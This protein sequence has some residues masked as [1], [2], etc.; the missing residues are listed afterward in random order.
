MKSIEPAFCTADYEKVS[1]TDLGEL[2]FPSDSLGISRVTAARSALGDFGTMNFE[3]KKQPITVRAMSA[4]HSL[5]PNRYRAKVEPYLL[6][7]YGVELIEV[8]SVITP[9]VT[10]CI[11]CRDLWR[12]E[13]DPNW[14]NRTIQLALRRDQ[15]D[16]AAALLMATSLAAKNICGFVDEGSTGAAFE[17]KLK[18]R[19]F[20]EIGYQRHPTCECTRLETKNL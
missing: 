12:S 5:S 3:A 11:G 14:C 4:N 20:R 1:K 13:N 10:A 15:L 17:V 2:G 6:I 7:E 19:T 8:S 16:D 9:G 18:S